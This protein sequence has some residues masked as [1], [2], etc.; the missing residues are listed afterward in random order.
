MKNNDTLN[1]IID[2]ALCYLAA[3]WDDNNEDDLGISYE[4]FQ[5]YIERFQKENFS[6]DLSNKKS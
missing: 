1:R 6:I 3:N 5:K 2:Y 4:N